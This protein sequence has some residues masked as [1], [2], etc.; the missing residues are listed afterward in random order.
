[1]IRQLYVLQPIGGEKFGA[2]FAYAEVAD[3]QNVGEREENGVCPRCKSGLGLLPWL[4]PHRIELTSTR[5]P[6]LL[7]GA[8]FDLIVSSRFRR[9]Y[10]AAGLTGITQ[11]DSPAEIV[12]IGGKPASRVQPPP[13]EYHNIRYLHGSGELDDERSGAIRSEGLCDYCRQG[14][15]K[16]DRVILRPGS[17]TGADF[18][19]AYGLP[20]HLLVSEKLK[21]LIESHQLTNAEL[22]PAEEYQFDMEAII[23]ALDRYLP[24]QTVH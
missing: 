1:M 6:D 9:H 7:W 13:P 20:G 3:P 8:G 21:D 16:V 10:E 5:Y 11:F 19:E 22:I 14:I 18:F 15:D 12:S 2:L 24:G 17:W 4:P 23:A